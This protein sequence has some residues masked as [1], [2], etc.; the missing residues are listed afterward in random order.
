MA[1]LEIVPGAQEG[2]NH[3]TFKREA[4]LYASRLSKHFICL[5]LLGA[6][7][8]YQT[9]LDLHLLLISTL[10][11][12]DQASQASIRP[13]LDLLAN[14]RMLSLAYAYLIS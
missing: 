7:E 12:W 14:L 6:K 11:T 8:I 1:R 4:Q 3:T 5:K 9:Y 10:Q 2:Y 13:P